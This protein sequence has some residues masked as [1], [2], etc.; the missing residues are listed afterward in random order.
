[1]RQSHPPLQ[2]PR[3]QLHHSQLHQ[4]SQFNRTHINQNNQNNKQQKGVEKNTTIDWNAKPTFAHKTKSI[5]SLCSTLTKWTLIFPLNWV[6]P[7]EE[8]AKLFATG[9]TQIKG[10]S[11][12]FIGEKPA[13]RY[14]SL[15]TPPFHSTFSLH[16]H[17]PHLSFI[18][19]F[20]I[21]F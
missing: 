3:Q 21:N 10:G 15:F 6:P 14:F 7:L 20:I 18:I 12:Y 1:M 11:L 19:C 8:I 17:L 5:M 16:L 9:T 4:T 2:Q 13:A